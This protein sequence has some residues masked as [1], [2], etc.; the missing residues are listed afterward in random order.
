MTLLQI[1]SDIHIEY[2][3]KED[4]DPLDYITPSAPTLILAGDIGSI[5]KIKQLTAF[6]SKIC[7]YF[8]T[9]LYVPGNHEY[10]MTAPFLG[11]RKDRLDSMLENITKHIPNLYIL[12]RKSILLGGDIC[13]AGCTLWSVPKCVLPKFLVRIKNITTRI[14]KHNHVK[15]LNYLV[16]MIKHCQTA[17]KK[18]VIVTHYPPTYQVLKNVKRRKKFLSLYGNDLDHLLDASKVNTWVCGHIH[19]N[20]DLVTEKGCRLVGNQKGK[21]KDIAKDYEKNKII[22]IQ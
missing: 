2:E 7:T 20:F 8:D 9:V 16:K 4:I 6:L 22:Q 1:V 10:Y 15:D 21:K 18:L 3:D 17:K 12:N 11:I 13:V 14:Y 5:Y 19:E